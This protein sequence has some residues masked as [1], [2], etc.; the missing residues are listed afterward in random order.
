MKK[1]V[2]FKVP[3]TAWIMLFGLLCYFPQ[4]LRAQQANEVTG[5][6]RDVADK[7]G[8]PGVNVQAKASGTNAATD[9]DG[10]YTIRAKAGEV[11]TFSFV[12]YVTQEIVLGQQSVL[13]VDLQFNTEA[14]DEV[15]VVGYGTQRRA[16]V[17]GAVSAINSER[18]TQTAATTTADALVGKMQGITTRSTNSYEGDARPGSPAVLQIRNMGE[19]LFIIDGIPQTSGQFNNLNVNDIENISILKDASASVYGFR[20]ANGVVLVTTKRGTSKAPQININGYYGVQNLTRFPFETPASAYLFHQTRA[21]SQQNRGLPVTMPAAEL[22]KWRLGTEPGYQSF[23][24]YDYVVNNPNA[25]QY[26]LN[27]SVSGGSEKTTYYFSAGHVNQDFVMKG[28]GFNRT[29]LQ[30]NLQTTIAKGLTVGTQLSYR[31]ENRDN[32]AIP[33]R[34]DPIWNAFLGANSSWPMDNPYANSNP[35][36]INGNV[37]YL[38][39]LPSTYT[40]EIAGWQKDVWNNA[41]GNFFAEYAFPFRLKARATYSHSIKMNKFDRQRY[42]YDAYRYVPES[43]TYEVFGGFSSPLRNRNRREIQDRFVQMQLSYDNSFKDHYFSAVMAYERSD[44]DDT[45]TAVQS[46]PPI[47]DNNL[48]NFVDVSD[49]STTWGTNARASVIGKVNYDYKGKYLLEILGRYDGSYLYAPQKR[50]GL[51]PGISA[52]WRISEEKFMNDKLSFISDLKLRASWGQ[53]G[54]EEGVSPWGYLGGATYGSSEYMLDGNVIVGARPRG[55]PVTNLSWVTSTSKNVGIDLS[56]FQNKITA[57]FDVFERRLSGLP[58]ARY[59]VLLP[60]EVGYSLPNENLESEANRGVE[61]II[62]YSGKKGDFTYNVGVNAT[63]SRRKILDRYKPR[64]GNSWD[65]Y[66]NGIENRWSGVNFGYQVIGQFQSMEQIENYPINNDGQG[67]TTLL[68]GDLIY[69][70]VNGDGVINNLDERPIGYA[71]YDNPILGFGLTSSFGYKNFS[72]SVDFAGGTMYSFNQNLELRF[73]FQGGHN[74]P[75]WM[76]KDRWRRADVYDNNS[77]WIPGK[78]PPIRENSSH[79]NY[80]NSDYWRTN[81]RYVRVRRIEVGYTMPTK[82]IEKAKMKAARLYVSATNPF[83]FDNLSHIELDP[84]LA[85]ESGLRYPTQKIVNVGF[86]LTF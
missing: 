2:Y 24:Q 64:F 32:V 57:Q 39:R 60:S 3:K 59:D 84:E 27:A 12:G 45:Y 36:Y 62:T 17:T 47:N 85:M 21:E 41:T 11:L 55:L 58:A 26:S 20:A 1:Q 63:L 18:L 61:G 35:N 6:V 31:I 4:S 28:H 42:S 16:S 23:N 10:K 5:T 19:P 54:R 15:V 9:K 69:K 51:F 40:K 34:E 72:L 79:S 66:R 25:A 74:S 78:Y 77:E 75:E 50:W 73:P 86:N 46:V 52:G 48:I 71:L 65:E 37:R 29:N 33:G 83:T 80:R 44:N 43:D 53:A 22:E 8:M 67:N 82:L 49:V 76:L 7:S 13:D 14:L 38:T 56:L 68:P 70:D 81:V 30:S